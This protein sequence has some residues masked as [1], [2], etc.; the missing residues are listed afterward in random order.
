MI[1]GLDADC[2]DLPALLTSLKTSCGAGGTIQ[3]DA[4]EIQGRQLDRVKA[5][6]QRIGFKTKG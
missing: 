5:E 2:N 3:D 6:L 4:I 1:R